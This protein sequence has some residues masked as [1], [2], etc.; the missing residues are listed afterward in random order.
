MATVVAVIPFANTAIFASDVGQLME[1]GGSCEGGGG[2]GGGSAAATSALDVDVG[3]KAVAPAYA[4]ESKDVGPAYATES[5]DAG[6]AYAAESKDAGPPSSYPPV[7]GGPR[8]FEE[9]TVLT[10]P[11]LLLDEMRAT[12]YVRVRMSSTQSP[13][14][15]YQAGAA[16]FATPS[17]RK[18][19]WR[20]DPW[21]DPDES[22]G[23]RSATTREFYEMHPLW[24]TENQNPTENQGIPGPPELRRLGAWCT[25]CLDMTLALISAIEAG[26]RRYPRLSEAMAGGVG[27]V[28]A[29]GAGGGGE[30]FGVDVDVGGS[31]R[32]HVSGGAGGVGETTESREADGAGA[33]AD[34]GRSVDGGGRGGGATE[35]HMLWNTSMLRLYRYRTFR[36]LCWLPMRLGYVSHTDLGLLTVTPRGTRSGLEIRIPCAPR[37]R[38]MRSMRPK[39]KWVQIEKQM[40]A[41]EVLIFPGDSLEMLTDGAY[42]PLVHRV[43]NWS[44]ATRM[45]A[46]FFLRAAKGTPTHDFVRQR[47]SDRKRGKLFV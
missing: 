12:G 46:P 17:A 25:S 23:F 30:N 7:G 4:T 8:I 2:G 15:L 5:K 43:V 44:H 29:G 16:F 3:T 21:A 38:S 35:A 19:R 32:A 47:R 1:G 20:V 41:D 33:G 28:R 22:T 37:G 36:P 13:V 10:D 45:S 42:R 9:L 11:G 18:N 24:Q 26:P 31:G 34:S 6:P 27:G 14:A 40:G 39:F